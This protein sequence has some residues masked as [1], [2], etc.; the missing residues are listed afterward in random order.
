MAGVSGRPFP[1][2]AERLWGPGMSVRTGQK[3]MSLVPSGR[4]R[5]VQLHLSARESDVG[6]ESGNHSGA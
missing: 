1:A 2:L 6:S 3:Q 4:A 5:Q